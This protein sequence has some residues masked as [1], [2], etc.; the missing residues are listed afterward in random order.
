MNYHS[1]GPCGVQSEWATRTAAG[2][3]TRLGCRAFLRSEPCSSASRCRQGWEGG[4]SCPG[5]ESSTKQ[6]HVS[7]TAP[8]ETRTEWVLRGLRGGE[9]ELG[10]PVRR[11]CSVGLNIY[12]QEKLQSRKNIN[13]NNHRQEK[14]DE[15]NNRK[16]NK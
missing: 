14:N 13:C 11:A 4:S 16:I 10:R 15:C 6:E 2:C 1:P 5:T 8:S 12:S 9:R 7:Q 3:R